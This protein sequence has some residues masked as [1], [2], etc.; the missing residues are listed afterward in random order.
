MPPACFYASSNSGWLGLLLSAVR[1]GFSC[2]WTALLSTQTIS[3]S[4]NYTL[5]SHL[6]REQMWRLTLGQMHYVY[7]INFTPIESPFSFHSQWGTQDS[8]LAEQ[9]VSLAIPKTSA[10]C[11]ILTHA[12]WAALEIQPMEAKDALPDFWANTPKKHATD[13]AH[14]WAGT[15]CSLSFILNMSILEKPSCDMKCEAKG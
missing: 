5:H 10:V 14:L 12:G 9:L 4:P 1:H 11:S 3:H 8:L 7:S 6:Y 13:S 15:S 2:W